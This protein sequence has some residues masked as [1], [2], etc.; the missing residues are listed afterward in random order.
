MISIEIF[1]RVSCHRD[2]NSLINKTS[3]LERRPRICTTV[4]AP[5]EDRHGVLMTGDVSK[6][7]SHDPRFYLK[8]SLYFRQ[9]FFVPARSENSAN[10]IVYDDE[11]HGIRVL[12]KIEDNTTSTDNIRHTSNMADRYNIFLHRC[13]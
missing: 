6:P 13:C 1:H 11:N 9:L 4:Y 12:Q 7:R 3:S 10:G 2:K 5:K 8:W